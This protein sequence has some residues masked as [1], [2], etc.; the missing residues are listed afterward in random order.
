MSLLF[1]SNWKELT[2]EVAEVA[3]DWRGELLG[4]LRVPRGETCSVNA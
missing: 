1:L 4:A 2:A 3:E